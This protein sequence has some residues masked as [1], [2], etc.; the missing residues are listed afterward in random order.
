MADRYYDYS[1][2][3]WRLVSNPNYL[4]TQSPA[5]SASPLARVGEEIT[6][7]RELYTAPIHRPGAGSYR[8]PNF[9]GNYITRINPTTGKPEVVQQPQE[10]SQ[11]PLQNVGGGGAPLGN[12]GG[13]STG[14]GQAGLGV[15]AEATADTSATTTNS[16]ADFAKAAFG[17]ITGGLV[18]MGREMFGDDP[19]GGP[20]QDQSKGL[21]GDINRGLDVVGQTVTG[22]TNETVPNLTGWTDPNAE[23]QSESDTDQ[24]V[25]GIGV[26]GVGGGT[27]AATGAN[28]AQ[29]EGSQTGAGGTS[30]GGSE[31]AGGVS[32]VGVGDTGA[33]TS[34]TAGAGGEGSATGDAGGVGGGESGS[35]S[36]AGGGDG[37]GNGGTY[38][39]GGVVTPGSL[40]GPNP[41][42]PDDG[43][44]AL[45]AGEVVFANPSLTA[46]GGGN[47]EAGRSLMS[48]ANAAMLA[49]DYQ[50]A[51]RLFTQVAQNLG[52]IQTG[53][54]PMQPPMMPQSA[55]PAPAPMPMAKP[56]AAPQVAPR[57]AVKAPP[58]AA[59]K[60]PAPGGGL[61][62]AA[63][64]RPGVPAAPKPKAKPNPGALTAPK[65]AVQAK[66]FK[67]PTAPKPKRPSTGLANIGV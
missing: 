10:R 17:G 34:G 64:P 24:G 40:T 41:P 42:G 61:K 50:T 11:S 60:P 18:N 26:G 48:Q 63:P 55:R 57:P 59:K 16:A 1:A 49:G 9:I 33:D 37:A 56:P 5:P 21:L 47:P 62:K 39:M 46:L 14:G 4:D 43:S 2:R 19:F 12:D 51:Q 30:S 20:N 23:A 67:K 8:F 6:G 25:S 65:Q 45:D 32:G 22:F 35:A 44:A 3:G 27:D 28:A 58:F 13:P 15:G 7:P 29:G 53:R 66:G 38:A 54:V 31:A 36:G 52:S